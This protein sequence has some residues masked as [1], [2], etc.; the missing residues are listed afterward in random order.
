MEFVKRCLF[1]HGF[2]LSIRMFFIRKYSI[3]WMFLAA[4]LLIKQANIKSRYTHQISLL[5]LAA[6]PESSFAITASSYGFRT[7]LGTWHFIYSRDFLLS[8]EDGRTKEK[9]DICTTYNLSLYAQKKHIIEKI[10][11]SCISCFESKTSYRF[12][13]Y[14]LRVN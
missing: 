12:E 10:I 2:I 14:R 4:S 3:L 11:R 7:D 8:K 9:V 5:E 6:K 1:Y 13:L